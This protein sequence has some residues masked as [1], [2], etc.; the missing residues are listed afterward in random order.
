[1]ATLYQLSIKE[2]RVKHILLHNIAISS[3]LSP[4]LLPISGTT[5]PLVAWQSFLNGASAHCKAT[6]LPTQDKA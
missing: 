3:A 4:V 5:N 6:V 2:T 1:L